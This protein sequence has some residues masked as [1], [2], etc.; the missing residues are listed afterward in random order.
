VGR[1]TTAAMSSDFFPGGVDLALFVKAN[2]MRLTS[3]SLIYI[4]KANVRSDSNIFKIGKTTS[5]AARLSSYVHT[6]GIVKKG[7]P[8]SG[9]KLIYFEI[10]PARVPGV[11][12]S[13]LIDRRE[14]ALAVAVLEAG[15]KLVSGR[16]RERYRLTPTQLRNAVESIPVVWKEYN[17]DYHESRQRQQPPREATTKGCA[18]ER[19]ETKKKGQRCPTVTCRAKN[20]YIPAK[21]PPGMSFSSY[22]NQIQLSAGY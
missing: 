3:L 8:Q 22:A 2:K 15:G 1:F 5:G 19:V 6:H 11:G 13:L 7:S 17:A 20:T 12:G 4:I 18:C 16:G 9:A 10:V 21:E 14:K